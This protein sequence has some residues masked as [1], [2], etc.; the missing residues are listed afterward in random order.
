MTIT[1]GGGARYVRH[2]MNPRRKFKK[3]YTPNINSS[4]CIQYKNRIR[5]VP[6]RDRHRKVRLLNTLDPFIHVNI[7]EHD[8]KLGWQNFQIINKQK[9]KNYPITN[10][11]RYVFNYSM[12]LFCKFLPFMP[13]G[14]RNLCWF[15]LK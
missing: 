5:R 11:K 4:K 10:F 14:L 3:N 8:G 9:I 13:Q 2:F 1:R 7:G 6:F 12:C 15:F